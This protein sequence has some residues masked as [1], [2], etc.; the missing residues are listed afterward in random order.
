MTQELLSILISWAVFLSPLPYSKPE[1]LPLLERHNHAW[2]VEHACPT[3][4]DCNV[5]AWYN[6]EGVIHL[7][8]T[9]DL[10]DGFTT[11]IVVHE[12]AHYL[13]HLQA[14]NMEPC[15]REREAYAIQNRYIEE[16]L[17]IQRRA[18]P[19]RRCYEGRKR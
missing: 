11:G 19:N 6:D 14:P 16:V 17:T 1:N 9:L 15:A 7:D 10:E 8:E 3:M 18:A 5:V 13:Q 4:D 2:F 12:F